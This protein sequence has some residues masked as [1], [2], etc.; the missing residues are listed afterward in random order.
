[1]TGH[2]GHTGQTW[3]SWSCGKDSTMA[4]AEVCAGGDTV[5]GLLTSV[6]GGGGVDAAEVAVSRVPVAL[7][8]RQAAALGLPVETVDLPWPC[9][10]AV[11]EQR[12][13]A[14]WRRLR[15][16]GADALV[17]GDLYLAEIRAYRERSLDGSGLTPRFPL[18]GRPTA[19]LAREMLDR[20][21][22]A[23]VVCVDPAQAPPEIVG[24]AWDEDLLRELPAHVD[25][26]GENGEFHTFVTDGPG[27]AE[28]VEVTV[29]GVA[30][31][32]GLVYARLEPLPPGHAEADRAA[33]P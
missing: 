15:E 32:D 11:Y 1:M 16:R 10:N 31:R 7:L 9:P 8:H 25:P 29:A 24:R 27:F 13:G 28:P 2:R 3:V 5:A 21:L 33:S 14:A 6:V 4:L 23:V 19:E 18:W 26:C 30:H 20:G 17:H 22:R 12:M